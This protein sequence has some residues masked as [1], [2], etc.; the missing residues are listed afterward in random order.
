M[1]EKNGKTYL[2]IGMVGTGF[3]TKAHSNAYHTMSYI[4]DKNKAR[5][6]LKAINSVTSIARAEQ[7]KER[8]GFEASGLGYESLIS[9]PDIDVVDICVGDELHYEIALAALK[10]GK[11][12]I[13]EKPLATS[14]SKAKEMA[15]V[16]RNSGRLALC[17][18]NYRFIPAVLLTKQ[19]IDSGVMGQV[20]NFEGSY[21]QDVGYDPDIRYENI[22]Y[23]AGPKASGVAYGIGCHLFDMARFIMGD[24]ESVIGQTINYNPFRMSSDGPKKVASPENVSALV[25]FRSGATGSFRASAVAAGRKNRLYYEISCAKGTIV[26]DLEEINY[27]RIFHKDS[28]VK[29]ISGFTKVNVTQIDKDHPFMD[30]WWPRGHGIGWEHAHINELAAFLES[31]AEGGGLNP[32]AASFHDGY[33]SLKIADAIL[34]SAESGQKICLDA[35][36]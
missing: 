19:L 20:Y 14:R 33:M 16:A 23:A 10:A 5:P 18:F 28:P 31:I 8:F 25:N 30:V 13:C 32:L 3:M 12:V 27:L 4:Y 1:T 21:M 29:Q 15:D 17:G 24:V 22:W 9:N 35:I 11:H 6:V 36:E 34:M 7:A 26:F 2:N